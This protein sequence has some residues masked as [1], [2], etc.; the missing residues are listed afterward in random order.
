VGVVLNQVTAAHG[1]DYYGY[2]GGYR[3]DED[4]EL[5]DPAPDAVD[6]PEVISTRL[7]GDEA[8]HS[9]PGGGRPVIPRRVA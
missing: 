1:G 7:S 6:E 2:D 4:D 5:D 8:E 3:Y 9:A